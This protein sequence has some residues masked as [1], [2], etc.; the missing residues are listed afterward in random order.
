MIFLD[1][2]DIITPRTP[3]ELSQFIEKTYELVMSDDE[4]RHRARLKEGL[5][6]A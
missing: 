1:G 6:K 4:T 5:Y 2:E 3:I